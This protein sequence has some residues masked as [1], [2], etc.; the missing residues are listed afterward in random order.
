VRRVFFAGFGAIVL[1]LSVLSAMYGYD[2]EYRFEVAAITVD[3]TV[4][5][6]AGAMLAA[7]YRNRS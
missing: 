6:V 4:L 2:V 7:L 3:W 5:V 1:S